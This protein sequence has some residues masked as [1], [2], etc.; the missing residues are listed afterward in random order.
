MELKGVKQSNNT[1]RWQGTSPALKG[2]AQSGKPIDGFKGLKQS[3]IQYTKSAAQLLQAFAV[4]DILKKGDK[5]HFD[6]AKESKL[7]TYLAGLTYTDGASMLFGTEEISLSATD[8]S[9]IAGIS[10]CYV[11]AFGN[12]QTHEMIVVYANKSGSFS[13]ITWDAGFNNLDNNGDVTLSLTSDTPIGAIND[14]TPPTWN[15]VI[16][17]KTVSQ[18]PDAN[19]ELSPFAVGDTLEAGSKIYFDTTKEAE[20]LAWLQANVGTD[21]E[22]S[23]KLFSDKNDNFKIEAMYEETPD[24]YMIMV[25]DL[26]GSMQV[27]GY[28]YTSKAIPDWYEKPGFIYGEHALNSDGSYT[29]LAQYEI[30]EVSDVSGW[31]GILIGKGE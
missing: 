24:A 6:T 7:K 29:P 19:I 12:S 17:G 26:S 14:T 22:N 21:P 9:V 1:Y 31:N 18:H 2:F 8:M 16:I 20:L 30:T 28:L 11:L 23:I 5:I 15:G 10:D 25:I 13:G 27:G 4:G 3:G